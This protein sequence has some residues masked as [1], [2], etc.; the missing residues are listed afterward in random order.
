M[1]ELKVTLNEDGQAKEVAEDVVYVKLKDQNLILRDVLGRSKIIEGALVEELD[2]SKE[3]LAL[4]KAP[5]LLKVVKFLTL[6][7]EVLSSGKYDQNIELAWE[8]VK[9]E[10]D[11]C[12]REA[13]TKLG[14]R[15]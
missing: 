13:W 12:I 6:Y 3:S 1:C 4:V 15:R 8:E 2:I 5:L 14:S 7:N 10:G 9:A 11:K